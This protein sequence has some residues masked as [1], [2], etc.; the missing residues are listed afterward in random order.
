MLSKSTPAVSLSVASSQ[1]EGPPPS[2]STARSSLFYQ[3]IAS[4]IAPERTIAKRQHAHSSSISSLSGLSPPHKKQVSATLPD[5]NDLKDALQSGGGTDLDLAR[6]L[7]RQLE[8]IDFFPIPTCDLLE[9]VVGNAAFSI[10]TAV[11]FTGTIHLTHSRDDLVGVGAFKTCEVARLNLYPPRFVGLGSRANQEIVVKRPYDREPGPPY[12]QLSL[13]DESTKLFREANVLYWSK[14][15]LNTTYNYIHNCI[16]EAADPPPFDIPQLRFVDA[17]LICAYAER[18]NAPK[19]PRAPKPGAVSMMYLAEEL[20]MRDFTDD[21]DH[22]EFIKFIHNGTATPRL[23]P[24]EIGFETAKFLAFTQHVQYTTTGGQ[25][26]IS[27]YQGSTTVLS[28]PQ[29]LT[30]P[31]VPTTWH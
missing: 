29:I 15:L 9:L 22:T 10:D 2:I 6:V 25:V 28:D 31:Y 13:T 23:E 27:D 17:G 12:A 1:S 26:Y 11:P 18:P 19:G 30:H 16:S 5:P 24:G 3:S 8:P 14:A 4:D 21:P 7:K 20:I